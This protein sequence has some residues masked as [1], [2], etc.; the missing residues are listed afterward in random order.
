MVGV[1]LSEEQYE[2]LMDITTAALELDSRL[3]P[4]E[5][6]FITDFRERAAKWGRK[7]KV[8]EKQWVILRRIQGKL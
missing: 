5:N 2:E 4:W 1:V 6:Q 7:V 3:T 8:S